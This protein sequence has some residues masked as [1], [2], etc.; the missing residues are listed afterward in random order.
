MDIK[1]IMKSAIH[2]Y[3]DV[4]KRDALAK[5]SWVSSF[6]LVLCGSIFTKTNWAMLGDDSQ[7]ILRRTWFY[8]VRVSYHD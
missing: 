4:N 2:H 7:T 8:G 3:S 5:E 6:L 1:L